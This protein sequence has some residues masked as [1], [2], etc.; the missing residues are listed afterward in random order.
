MTLR[1][2]QW[3]ARSGEAN[4]RQLGH[5]L[6]F[7]GRAAV[8]VPMAVRRY[9]S[10]VRRLIG[11]LTLG[12]GLLITFTGT[13]GVVFAEA[14][15][16]GI[17]V[18]VEGFQSL[19]LLG[20]APLTG[21]VSAYANTREIAPLIAAVAIA[22]Q[23]GCKFTAQLGAQRISEEIDA[24]EVMA[25]PS[26]PYLVSTRIVAAF[27]AVVP[28]YLVGLFG[29]Y[30]A[31]RLTVLV[32][33]HQSLGTYD[34]YFRLFLQP[35]DILYSVLKVLVF[36][37]FITIVHT[38]YGYH[39]SGGP[40]GVGRAAARAIRATTVLIATSDVLMTMLFWGLHGVRL[41]GG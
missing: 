31:T 8:G 32:L 17:E 21:F 12:S 6:I 36:T 5:A 23:I 15:F 27:T 24:L 9:L 38:Y 16:V 35:V 2:V 14:V 13:L 1:S 30:G 29:S 11:E 10:E 22:A 28:L 33:F 26:L 19:N 39:A 7:A 37:F 41:S 4:V 3:A 18:G 20:V 34:H 40:E 25:V